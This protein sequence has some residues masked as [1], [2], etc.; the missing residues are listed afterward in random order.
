MKEN[1]A[2]ILRDKLNQAI[3]QTV[4]LR[5]NYADDVRHFTRNRKLPMEEL[6]KLLLTMTGE[7]LARELYDTG[8]D[9]APSS[10]V[11]Q[12]KRI[13]FL[14]FKKILERFNDLCDDPATL[15]GYRLWAVDGSTIPCPRNPNSNNHFKS[16]SNPRGWNNTHANLM[17]DILNRTFVDCIMSEG[18]IDSRKAHDE[19][20]ALCSLI[21]RRKFQQ[22]TIIMLDRGYES[23]S[24][25]YQLGNISNLYYVLRVKNEGLRPIKTLPMEELDRNLE[26]T[27][28]SRQGRNYVSDF[29]LLLAHMLVWHE[30]L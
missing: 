17:F 22:P 21:F 5:G 1:H 12:R 14:A 19:Q 16:E 9:M 29:S 24:S 10:F 23:F 30:Y 15:K 26:W 13:S 2:D 3:T 27:V 8:I 7:T 6:I 11:E 18:A 4:S 28:T 25:I 20:D